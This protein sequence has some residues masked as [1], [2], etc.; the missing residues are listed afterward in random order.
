MMP[1][2][3][4]KERRLNSTHAEMMERI[5]IVMKTS[6]TI[7]MIKNRICRQYVNYWCFEF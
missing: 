3:M 5:L 7:L 1:S 2:N 4:Q 6:L